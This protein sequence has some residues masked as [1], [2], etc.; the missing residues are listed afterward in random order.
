MR[1]EPGF[2]NYSP[3]KAVKCP[4]APTCSAALP[5]LPHPPHAPRTPLGG[6]Q[7]RQN[8]QIVRCQKERPPED[9]RA[10]SFPL[11]GG[12]TPTSWGSLHA[13]P[14]S[15]PIPR[16]PRA[17]VSSQGTVSPSE[18]QDVA[19]LC[20][21][22]LP[23]I[24]LLVSCPTHWTSIKNPKPIPSPQVINV[25]RSFCKHKVLF[26]QAQHLIKK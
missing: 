21:P 7:R 25:L 22:T 26:L 13:Q 23:E 16:P 24:S 17:L 18:N 9:A 4:G 12:L 20:L 5:C 8:H 10:P 14:I 19:S 1:T 2:K 6:L 3:C 11:H 15:R